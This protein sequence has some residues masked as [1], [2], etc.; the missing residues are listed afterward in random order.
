MK[1]LIK[2]LAAI[3]NDLKKMIAAA[4]SNLEQMNKRMPAPAAPSRKVVVD[5]RLNRT[6]LV[7]HILTSQN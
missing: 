7:Q 6:A 2:S 1:D 4:H 5:H 3:N